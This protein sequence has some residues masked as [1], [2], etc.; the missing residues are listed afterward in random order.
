MIS[1]EAPQIYQD[2]EISGP[3]TQEKTSLNHQIK[4]SSNPSKYLPD[5]RHD[6]R[7]K[8]QN[9]TPQIIKRLYVR[10]WRMREFK[11]N[12]IDSCLA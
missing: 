12:I 4:Y 7:P 8:K 10:N 2:K 5:A 1:S 11:L 9:L 6:F 3:T